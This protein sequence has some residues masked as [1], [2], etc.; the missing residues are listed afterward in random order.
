MSVQEIER[1]KKYRIDVIYGYEGNKKLRHTETFKG[2]KSDAIIRE[3]AIKQEI[4][5]G[6]FIKET[7]ITINNL[8]DE[9]LKKKKKTI[10]PKTYYNYLFRTNI[11]KEKLGF[12]KLKD[13]NV[14]VLENFYSYLSN[15]YIQKNGKKLSSTTILQYYEIIND[16]INQAIIWDYMR[17]NPNNKIDK[18]KKNK[19]KIEYYTPEEVIQ[20]MKVIENEPIETQALLCLAFDTG[21][22]R[23]EITGLTW[24]DVNFTKHCVDINKITQYTNSKTGIYEKETKTENSNRILPISDTTIELLRKHQKEQKE[25]KLQLGNKWENSNRV[26][27]NEMGGNMQP[28]KPSKILE[29]VLKKYNLKHIHF[30]SIRHTSASLM[31]NSGIQTQII[32]RKLGHSSIQTTDRIYS[33][34]YEDEFKKTANIMDEY[35]NI[36]RIEKAN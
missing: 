13:L 4:R 14:K 22:R 30:H 21:C 16:M 31:I 2:K 9:W 1:N 6:I 7:G 18:P 33:H 15:E 17:N 34:F 11:I 3:N 25:R 10:T 8:V 35:L 28:N 32:A 5:E 19:P 20:L 27:T 29:Y 36:N 24:D 26:F 23:G 12:I